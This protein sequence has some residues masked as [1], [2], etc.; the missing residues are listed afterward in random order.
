MRAVQVAEIGAEGVVFTVTAYG[1]RGSVQLHMLGRHNVH[2]ALAA[3]AVGLRSGISLADCA[4]ALGEMRAGRQAWG[5]L[6]NGM[7]LR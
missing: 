7:A 5:N 2:N 4:S 1:E 3:I 6:L